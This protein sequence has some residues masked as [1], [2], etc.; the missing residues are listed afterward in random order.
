[1]KLKLEFRILNQLTEI[2]Q[3]KLRTSQAYFSAQS[4]TMSMTSPT[5]TSAG[6]VIPA[7]LANNSPGTK[8]DNP[9]RGD[10]YATQLIART[11]ESLGCG[12]TPPSRFSQPYCGMAD[13]DEK[14]AKITSPSL[15]RP[16]PMRAVTAPIGESVLYKNHSL[17]LVT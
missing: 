10:G 2:A 11:R 7:W 16:S 4:E 13:I 17:R 6:A 14:T 8:V 1:M 9:L 15:T 3:E 5:T 12:S